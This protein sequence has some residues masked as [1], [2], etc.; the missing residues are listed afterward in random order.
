R[1]V[2]LNNLMLRKKMTMTKIKILVKNL[3]GKIVKLRFYLIIFKK[4]SHL[5]LK[6]IKLNFIM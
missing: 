3:V 4:I 6:E 5:G 2:F 1:R